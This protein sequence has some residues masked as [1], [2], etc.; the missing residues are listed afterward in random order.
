MYI[1][2]ESGE[3]DIEE[4]EGPSVPWISVDPLQPDLGRCCI[5]GGIRISVRKGLKNVYMIFKICTYTVLLI[6]TCIYKFP[7]F[8]GKVFRIR[9][10]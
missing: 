7:F 2:D 9:R 4:L 8:L 10:T 6:R 1:C 5:R 3:F